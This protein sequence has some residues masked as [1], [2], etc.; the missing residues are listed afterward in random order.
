MRRALTRIALAAWLAATGISSASAGTSP[1]SGKAVLIVHAEDPYLPWVSELSAGIVRELQS[2]PD[3]L[4]PDVYVEYLDL[5][6]F[7]ANEAADGR[8]EWLRQKYLGRKMDAILVVS[9]GA[10]RFIQPL[11]RELWPGVPIVLVECDLLLRDFEPPPGVIPVIA[12][13]EIAETIGLAKAVVP[14][15]RRVAFVM[16]APDFEPNEEEFVRREIQSADETLEVIDLT[17]LPMA[18]LVQRIAALPEDT[19]VFY[20]AIRIDGAGQPFIPREAL[21]HVASFSN[22]PIFSTHATMVGY[23]LTGGRLLDYGA[24]GREAG[25][26]LVRLLGDEP[27]AAIAPV[28]RSFSRPVFDARELRRFRIPERRLPA[29]NDIRFREQSLWQRYPRT[30]A[31]VL[32]AF[33]ILGGLILGLLVER[34]RRLRAEDETR[35]RRQELAHAGRLT[36]VGELT[37]SISHEI[38]QP[39]GAI[40]ANAE[41]AEMLLESEKGDLDEVR[42]ILADIRRDDVRASE[43]VRRVRSLAGKR[44]VE[45]QELDVNSVVEAVVRLVEFEAR[46]LGVA[47][48]T[49]LAPNLRRIRGDEVSI[50]QVLINLALNGMEAMANTLP[51]ERRLR[52][53]TRSD[54]SRVE[55]SVSDFGRGIAEH[56]RGSLFQPFFTTKAHG[57]GLGL[58]ICRSIA[59]AH[60]GHIAAENGSGRGAEFILSLPVHA[61]GGRAEEKRVGWRA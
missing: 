47:V 28:G 1:G 44:E 33:V 57:V 46:R 34:R 52:I 58:S 2:P 29:G 17:G 4:R 45:M 32:G 53:R 5:A 25:R 31:L 37:A 10:L 13:Y 36:A 6:R 9:R 30:A 35:L 42:Q 27:P 51:G 61:P 43:V 8:A 3:S 39:L 14:G 40:L 15:T 48:E 59:E 49:V 26:T 22:R 20:W 41:A 16:G 11:A 21:R 19:I 55:L 7:P 50:Q 12:R 38:N 24:V 54:G 18:E 56:E 23:G 60:G